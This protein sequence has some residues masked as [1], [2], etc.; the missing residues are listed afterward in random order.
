[1]DI[2]SLLQSQAQFIME[3]YKAFESLKNAYIAQSGA[4]DLSAWKDEA[5]APIEAKAKKPSY[6]SEEEF[7]EQGYVDAM[8][9]WK[10]YMQTYASGEALGDFQEAFPPSLCLDQNDIDLSDEN[11]WANGMPMGIPRSV[12]VHLPNAGTMIPESLLKGRK[13]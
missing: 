9:E 6:D 13:G 3:Q 7:M 5:P 12:W 1:M 11:A 2:G 8:D 4:T 10:N